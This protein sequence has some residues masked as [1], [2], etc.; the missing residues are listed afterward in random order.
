MTDRRNIR[1]RRSVYMCDCHDF[2]FLG[3]KLLLNLRYTDG[4]GK[5]STQLVNLCSISLK[6]NVQNV[7]QNNERHARSSNYMRTSLR[8][9]RRNTPR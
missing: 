6:A 8:S 4:L 1:T 5:V 7:I 2:V 3:S 9:H